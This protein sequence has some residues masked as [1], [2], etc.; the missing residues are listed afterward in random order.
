MTL[1]NEF[2]RDT[3][4]KVELQA[5]DV[6]IVVDVQNDFLS[7]GSLAVPEGNAVIPVLNKYIL[8]FQQHNLPVIASRDWH[9]DNHCSFIPQGGRWPPHCVAGSDGANFSAELK[10]PENVTIVS[11]ATQL[12]KDVYSAFEDTGLAEFLHEKKVTRVFVG[13]LATD[14]CV[15]NTVKD[16]IKSGFEVVLL[17]DAIKAVNVELEDGEKA[18]Q[19]MFKLG[20]VA[21]YLKAL[22]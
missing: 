7:G 11:K 9:P 20:A 2:Y 19:Q 12:E 8:H 21:I 6:L 3:L 1:T 10:L 18:I 5:H 22:K 14:Y 13:G 4:E 17:L 15:L 16:A